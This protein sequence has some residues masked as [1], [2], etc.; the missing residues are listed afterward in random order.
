MVFIIECIVFCILFTIMVYCISRKPI[1]TLYNYP[2][3]IIERVKS[4]KEYKDEVPTEKNKISAK[5]G[6]SVIFLLIMVL[7]LR[8]VNGYEMFLD[9]FLW[10]FLLWTIVN[11][12]DLVVLDFLW[13]CQDP[14]YVFR[15]T[16][17]MVS[18]YHNYWFHT[19]GFLIGEVLGL[20]LSLLSAFIIHFVL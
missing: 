15:G 20:I 12:Y 5:L 16:E 11:F 2:P 9:A 17:D 8:Y 10:G 6:A 18:E 7:L 19:K 1:Q 13:F 4:L 14:F 3:K